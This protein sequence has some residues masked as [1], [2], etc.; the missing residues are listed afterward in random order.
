[1]KN[2]TVSV[3]EAT[4]RRARI[5]AA[6]LDRSVSAVVRQFLVEFASGESDFERRKRLQDVAL[7]SISAFRAGGRLTRDQVH[8]R[9]ALR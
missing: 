9:D 2:I 1:M 8:D 7:A 6:E 4:Y 5:R 3:D